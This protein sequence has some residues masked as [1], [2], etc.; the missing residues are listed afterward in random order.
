MKARHAANK[1]QKGRVRKRWVDI[2][3]LVLNLYNRSPHSSLN[4]HSPHF[5][6]KPEN[7]KAIF[8]LQ[9]TGPVKKLNKGYY[10]RGTPVRIRLVGGSFGIRASDVKNSDEIFYIRRVHPSKPFS[11]CTYSRYYR[12]QHISARPLTYSLRDAESNPLE[13]RFYHEQLVRVS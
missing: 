11:F 13:D 5:A 3:E 1:E 10:R 4:N 8:D 12:S 2:A 6:S 9:L 7:W